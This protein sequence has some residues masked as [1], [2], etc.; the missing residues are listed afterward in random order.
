[1]IGSGSEG[2]IDKTG[3]NDRGNR[4]LAWRLNTTRLQA[5]N[6]RTHQAL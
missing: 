3:G 1:M 5:K 4:I 6:E 2:R